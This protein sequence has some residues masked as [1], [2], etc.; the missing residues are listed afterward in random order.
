MSGRDI[1][2]WFKHI[3]AKCLTNE[4]VSLM[5]AGP[6]NIDKMWLRRRG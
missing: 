4:G 3:T 2:S 6:I 5:L 1:L